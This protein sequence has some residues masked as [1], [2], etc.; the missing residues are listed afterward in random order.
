MS[1]VLKQPEMQEKM[2]HLMLTEKH[3]VTETD[4]DVAGDINPDKTRILQQL[5]RK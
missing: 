4:V 2:I 3:P 1:R 5:S